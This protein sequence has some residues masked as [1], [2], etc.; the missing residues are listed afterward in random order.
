MKI[1]KIKINDI[2]FI[3]PI[4][5]L[6]IIYIIYIS[7]LPLLIRRKMN[8]PILGYF[9]LRPYKFK[10]STLINNFTQKMT[11]NKSIKI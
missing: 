11:K 4:N 9:V 10:T 2:S 7:T 8:H 3:L 5:I 1:K 6:H